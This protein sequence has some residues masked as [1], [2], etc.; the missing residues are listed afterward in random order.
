[1]YKRQEEVEDYKLKASTGG[2]VDTAKLMDI[3]MKWRFSYRE[4]SNDAKYA[5]HE[6]A[7]FFIIRPMMKFME[8]AGDGAE[9][10]FL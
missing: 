6:A 3:V 8:A 1:M 9:G 5:W 7:L 10:L 4:G 2:R